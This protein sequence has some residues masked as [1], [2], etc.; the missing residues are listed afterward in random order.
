MQKVQEVS[1]RERNSLK[2]DIQQ[3]LSQRLIANAF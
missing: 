3:D 1:T 2:K